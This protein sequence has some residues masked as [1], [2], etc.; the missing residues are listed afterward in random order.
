MTLTCVGP[1][2]QYLVS[3]LAGR[4]ELCGWVGQTPARPAPGARLRELWKR[5]RDPLALWDHL[6]ARK[7]NRREER[8]LEPLRQ[9]LFYLQGHPP[10]FPA[11]CPHLYEDNVNAA[12]CADFIRSCKPEVIVVNG[13]N[14]L[15]DSILD[16]G[17]DCRW[18]IINMHTGLS[19]YCRG[20]NCNLHAV[21]HRQIQ[22]VGVT[23]HYIDKG[24]DS[25][26][27][28][29]TGRPPVERTDTMESLEEKTFWLG[30]ELV[31]AALEDLREGIAQRVPQWTKG[32]L[33]LK[34]T[35][36]DYRPRLRVLANAV[37]H[38]QGLLR[39]YLMHQ[40]NYDERVRLITTP[41][42][43]HVA[44]ALAAAG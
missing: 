6:S 36:Y 41:R 7:S 12:S 16:L 9:R 24:I 20:G 39:Q 4:H 17:K 10:E 3:R 22:F 18:G 34:R 29:L 14:L 42:A 31:L 2:Q 40:R 38:E 35:G 15:R 19:P 11:H 21:L 43:E 5:Y 1:H 37:L 26:D 44:Q 27:I 13:T 33:F 25:G 8:R 28:L 32:H 30:V 23:V